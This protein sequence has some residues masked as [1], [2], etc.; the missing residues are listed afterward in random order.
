MSVFGVRGAGCLQAMVQSFRPRVAAFMPA[1]MGIIAIIDQLQHRFR[2][3]RF[4][5]CVP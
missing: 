4:S 3:I 5:W 1:I 2:I